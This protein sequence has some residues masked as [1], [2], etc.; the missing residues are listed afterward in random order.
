MSLLE[1]IG[2]VVLLVISIFLIVVIMLQESKRAGMS[3]VTGVSDSYFGKNGSRTKEA[4]L[5]LL[6]K[7]AAGAFFVITILMG[8][9]EM[10]S[11]L[12]A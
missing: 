7:I 1:I 10:I 11:N 6:T 9:L 2:G 3:A 5:A 12:S 4:R 8:V